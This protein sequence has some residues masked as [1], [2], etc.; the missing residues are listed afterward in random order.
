[1]GS[2]REIF[3]GDLG[4]HLQCFLL[5][6]SKASLVRVTTADVPVRL[7][8]DLLQPQ[9][10]IKLSSKCWRQR[11]GLQIWGQTPRA[12]WISSCVNADSLPYM[13]S[14]FCFSDC[15]EAIRKQ[16]KPHFTILIL[17]FSLSGNIWH[18]TLKILDSVGELPHSPVLCSGL[19]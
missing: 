14:T 7:S 19:H 18:H 8:H 15:M 12:T 2:R 16:L 3:T 5:I 4:R 10:S 1:M 13:A 11:G 17:L 6:N 9:L